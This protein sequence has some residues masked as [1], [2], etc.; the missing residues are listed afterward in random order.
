M[1][2]LA[3]LA[4]ERLAGIPDVPT[5][6]EEGFDVAVGTW[7]GIGVPKETPDEIVDKI[8]EIFTTAAETEGFKTFMANNNL[9]IDIMNPEEFAARIASD[10]EM[11]KV[12]ISDLG[13]AQ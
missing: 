2:V 4:P 9:D 1:K 6:K 11:F 10:N 13:L 7:R 12:L 5:A 3:V 8:Y